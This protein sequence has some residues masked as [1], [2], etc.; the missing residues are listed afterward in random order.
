MSLMVSIV[1]ERHTR[2]TLLIKL[3]VLYQRNYGGIYAFLPATI[4]NPKDLITMLIC[5]TA[6]R[7]KVCKMLRHD[8]M[9]NIFLQI[10]VSSQS[11]HK[12]KFSRLS[13]YFPCY[14]IEFSHHALNYFDPIKLIQCGE[15]LDTFYVHTRIAKLF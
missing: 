2:E 5:S 10:Q 3:L 14:R 11:L 1:L 13:N 9:P 8:Q 4:T 6:S 7:Y 15:S 12:S